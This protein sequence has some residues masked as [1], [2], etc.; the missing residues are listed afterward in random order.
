MGL[1][2]ISKQTNTQW[3]NMISKAAT[4]FV[5]QIWHV[6]SA[7][8]R[9]DD[10]KRRNFWWV[11]LNYKQLFHGDLNFAPFTTSLTTSAAV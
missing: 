9:N 2:P 3:A 1:I 11:E 6:P 7:E 10:W 8:F 4:F 5:L